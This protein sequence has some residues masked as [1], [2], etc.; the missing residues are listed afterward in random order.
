MGALKP[1]GQELKGRLPGRVFLG[2]RWGVGPQHAPLRPAPGPGV[3][4]SPLISL[5]F[6]ILICFSVAALFTKRYSVR[7]LIVA[8]ILRSI[9]Y[10]GI[11][12]TLNILGALNVSARG[13]P[14]TTLY[15]P[16]ATAPPHPLVPGLEFQAHSTPA[17]GTPLC[18][19][20]SLD[21][22]DAGTRRPARSPSVEPGFRAL[23]ALS[24]E[25]GPDAVLLETAK[26][27]IFWHFADGETKCL[28][29]GLS[30]PNSVAVE[31]KGGLLRPTLLFLTSLSSWDRGTGGS[32]VLVPGAQV[33]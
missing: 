14:P 9:Y 24:A 16:A 32:S 23:C 31:A 17:V 10:L 5:L 6:W 30:F 29:Q 22:W 13:S 26:L 7:P 18:L 19:P 3:L 27:C 21:N 33:H 4:D 1:G 28:E 8:L 20:V 2:V 25:H 11:G 15:L 12:P